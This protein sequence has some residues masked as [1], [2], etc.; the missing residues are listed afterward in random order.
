M[1]YKICEAEDTNYCIK[2]NLII[3]KKKNLP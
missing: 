2:A 1:S 3:T